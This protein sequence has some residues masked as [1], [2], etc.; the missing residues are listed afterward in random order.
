MTIKEF[1]KSLKG[2]TKKE[3]IQAIVDYKAEIREGEER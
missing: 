2:K 1:I 3:I